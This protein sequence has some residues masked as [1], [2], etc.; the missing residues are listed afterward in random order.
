MLDPHSAAGVHAARLHGA[1]MRA[2]PMVSLATAHA[3]K[4]PDAIERAIGIRPALPPRLAQLAARPERVTELPADLG[5]LRRF[6]RD[7]VHAP[8]QERVA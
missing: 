6:V 7:R 3:A 4:F 2:A 1:G 8:A 5:L